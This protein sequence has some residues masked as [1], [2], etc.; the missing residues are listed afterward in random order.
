V[1]SSSRLVPVAFL[2]LAA[3]GLLSCATT[4]RR[5]EPYILA[6]PAGLAAPFDAWLRTVEIV[7][8]NLPL[9][10]DYALVGDSLVATASRYGMRLSA[11][12]NG[13]P[14]IVDVV[15]HEH[16]Y[17]VDISSRSSVMAILTVS[18]A[19]G[20][21]APVVRVVHSFVTTDSIA[22]FS[23]VAEIDETLFSALRAA[24]DK[25]G[26]ARAQGSTP[27]SP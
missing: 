13:Q 4:R 19:A 22:S 26:G 5:T 16:T 14:Y 6:D 12:R 23:L 10:Q 9:T 11:T 21:E 15:M 1:K 3:L 7:S 27:D 25:K 8:N 2:V 18:G 20:T 17:S 24:I